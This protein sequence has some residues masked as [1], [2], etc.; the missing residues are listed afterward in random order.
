LVQDK[1]PN[2]PIIYVNYRVLKGAASHFIANTCITDM[3]C[4][5]LGSMGATGCS[6]PEKNMFLDAL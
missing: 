1:Q 5:G 4:S 6:T 2:D 3:R